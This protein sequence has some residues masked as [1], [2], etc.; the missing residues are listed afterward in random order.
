MMHR[1][2]VSSAL[3]M[4]VGNTSQQV[5]QFVTFILLAR[6]LAPDI[7]GQVALAAVVID[8]A[9]AVGSW[10]LPQ[11]LTQRGIL[12]R[13][14]AAHA[15]VLSLI[16]AFALCALIAGGVGIYTL[17]RDFTL[18]PQLIL[19]M[20]PIIVAQAVSIVPEAV[21][22]RN[23]EFKWLAIQNNLAAVLGGGAALLMAFNDLGVYALVGQRI[24]ALGV[25]S[26]TI[27]FAARKHLHLLKFSQYKISTFVLISKQSLRIL[28]TRISLLLSLRAMDGIV[29]LH[30]GEAALGQFKIV[31]RIFELLTQLALAP[32]SSVAL[33]AFPK[34]IPDNEA[35]RKFYNTMITF[36]LVLFVPMMT[37]LAFTG[38]EWV[39][40]VLSDKWID[41]IPMFMILSVTSVQYVLSEYQSYL[42]VS[43]RWNHFIF[44]QNITKLILSVTATYIG[45]Q[46]SI[47]WVLI[48]YAVY[49]HG[50]AIYN[51]WA[52]NRDRGWPWSDM[53]K[54]IYPS[55]LAAIAMVGVL[56]V[57]DHYI[58]AEA[59]TLLVMNVAIGAAA[60]AALL[61]LLSPSLAKQCLK[62]VKTRNLNAV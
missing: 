49:S 39:P 9:L 27:W 54:T 31:W 56:K 36:S 5:L 38:T 46:F 10:G 1:N 50:L 3:W 40:L 14:L 32:L 62:F 55:A 43:M 20:M 52:I 37:G 2:V 21:I 18:I 7:F 51:A 12:S 28:S 24:I 15:F 53:V 47:A 57:A 33:A 6:Q 30:L 42:Q 45:A 61:F 60:Y 48:L 59:I 29:G 4:F 58:A 11:F 34:L 23:L 16:L 25:M 17:F 26:V 44:K 13:K 8:I 35:L 22:K 19:L 41:V